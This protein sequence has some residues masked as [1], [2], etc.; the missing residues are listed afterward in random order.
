MKVSKSISLDSESS[1]C[2]HLNNQNSEKQFTMTEWMIWN[3][4]G[5]IKK[6][7]SNH[8]SFIKVFRFQ[9]KTLLFFR[10]EILYFI[11]LFIFYYQLC[12][13]NFLELL[14]GFFITYSDFTINALKY[15]SFLFLRYWLLRYI[16]FNI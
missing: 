1:V 12:T 6:K 11:Y 3:M 2:K 14:V 8:S 10:F 4:K 9:W 13:S 16:E 5:K 15:F 7:P